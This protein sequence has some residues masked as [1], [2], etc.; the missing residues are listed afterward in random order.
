MK[1]LLAA[2]LIIAMVFGMARSAGADDI[3]LMPKPTQPPQ[4]AEWMD[5]IQKVKYIGDRD[6]SHITPDNVQR[7]WFSLM[8]ENEEKIAAPS[9]VEVKIVN[10]NEELVYEGTHYL[11]PAN[12]G[13]W[14]NTLTN[15]GRLLCSFD[16]KDEAI[17]AGSS[18]KG[19]FTMTVHYSSEFYNDGLFDAISFP[20]WTTEI[21][22]LPYASP[23]D[24]CTIELPE[25][26][27]TVRSMSGETV[28]SI[29][30]IDAIA[31]EFEDYGSEGEVKLSIMFTGEKTHDMESDLK[32][33]ACQIGYKLYHEGYVI[34]SGVLSTS[35][36]TVGEKYK[37]ETLT[38]SGLEPGK[39][40]LQILDIE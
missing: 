8:D 38:F 27:I 31:Y 15:T 30:R 11:S 37:N 18:K 5:L 22:G 2:A 32:N 33:R 12:F 28:K 26:P 16:I 1:N 40:K 20:E 34:K 29:T 35:V 6:V 14:T 24:R 7:V 19:I 9:I 4:K 17:R 3:Q 39:F 13:T 25:S 36:L 21:N 10:D 23:S